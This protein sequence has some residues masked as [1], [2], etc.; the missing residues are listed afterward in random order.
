MFFQAC[1]IFSYRY[2]NQQD[3]TANDLKSFSRTFL[4]NL[5]DTGRWQRDMTRALHEDNR[6]RHSFGH[7]G[8]E[9]DALEARHKAPEYFTEEQSLRMREEILT[10]LQDSKHRR[11]RLERLLLHQLRFVEMSDRAYGIVRAHA[12][13][14]DWIF[15]EPPLESKGWSNFAEWL[16]G[17]HNEMYWIT[18]KPG[19]GKS[20]LVKLICQDPR[21]TQYLNSWLPELTLITASFYFWN[22]GSHIQMSVDG[23]LRTLLYQCLQQLPSATS[24]LFP[25]RMNAMLLFDEDY[26]PWTWLELRRA[27]ET[28]LR[29]FKRHKFVFFVDGLDECDGDHTKLSQL[30]LCLLSESSNLKLCVASRPWLSFE[31]AF[32][33][34]PHLLLSN[35]TYPDICL[36]INDKFRDNSGFLELEAAQPR[37]AAGLIT[38]IATK[39]DGVFLWV[40]LVVQSL[41]DG[42]T[43]GELIEDLQ[44]RLDSIPPDLEDLF[45][46]ILK[47]IRPSYC[48]ESSQIFQLVRASNAPPPVSI[49]AHALS[50]IRNRSLVFSA[51]ASPRQAREIL[52]TNLQLRRRLNSR[53]KGLLEIKWRPSSE[54]TLEPI[55][56]GDLT[57]LQSNVSILLMDGDAKSSA[58]NGTVQFLHRTVRDF[59][60]Q[61]WAWAMILDMNKL[62]SFDAKACLC[63]AFLLDLKE[64]DPEP[65]GLLHPFW[66]SVSW[67]V[68]YACE[69]YERSGQ[70]PWRIFNELDISASALSSRLGFEGK[71]LMEACAVRH[72]VTTILS[73]SLPSFL[74][75]SAVFNFYWFTVFQRQAHGSRINDFDGCPVL[76]AVFFWD[77]SVNVAKDGNRNLPKSSALSL[78]SVIPLIEQNAGV[79]ADPVASREESEDETGERSHQ[80][81]N[82]KWSGH[83]N[84][85]LKRARAQENLQRESVL[86]SSFEGHWKGHQRQDTWS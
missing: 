82:F 72:W 41:L 56:E 83:W 12:K 40:S 75:I 27:M 81:R 8:P 21:T 29:T 68:E 79:Q 70:V 48:E 76:S 2:S 45:H 50:V 71:S 18:G 16:R 47:T 42:L 63:E 46:K 74:Q 78:R 85:G 32:K 23:L 33:A 25:E 35:F 52:S 77:G 73:L 53:C 58:S 57:K 4:L 38:S 15:R 22:S 5:E 34:R 66:D 7:D 67:C 59:F 6:H 14:M 20:T 26:S 10:D 64:L 11:Q 61:E 51:P 49:L 60:Q 65:P 44:R 43:D 36:Y 13:T 1:N 69:M 54:H 37:Y 39:S 3:A 9:Y 30:F 55:L 17:E 19:S 84:R 86:D 80:N 62:A 24:I 31:E 28:L